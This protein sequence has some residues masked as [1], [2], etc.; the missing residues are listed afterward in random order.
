MDSADEKTMNPSDAKVGQVDIVY[1]VVCVTA[2]EYLGNS[3]SYKVTATKPAH[4]PFQR[5]TLS[6]LPWNVSKFSLERE[7]WPLSS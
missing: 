7:L 2:E 3:Q 1:T 6:L 4:L 5:E